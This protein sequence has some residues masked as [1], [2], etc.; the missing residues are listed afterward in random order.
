M[1]RISNGHVD[2]PLVAWIDAVRRS[3]GHLTRVANL[4]DANIRQLAQVLTEPARGP[5]ARIRNVGPHIFIAKPKIKHKVIDTMRLTSH[6]QNGRR[7]VSSHAICCPMRA[8]LER[9]LSGAGN[10]R[11]RRPGTSRAS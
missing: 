10:A 9:W 8:V 3:I 1:G 6:R 4:P 7:E 2:T 5:T 11:G